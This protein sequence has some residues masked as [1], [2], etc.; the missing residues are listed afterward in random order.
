MIS[1]YFFDIRTVPLQVGC[2]ELVNPSLRWQFFQNRVRKLVCPIE[3]GNEICKIATNK[4]SF[5]V[6]L[7]GEF[8]ACRGPHLVSYCIDQ[9]LNVVFVA[10]VNNTI[11]VLQS[12]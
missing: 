1:L 6:M 11:I 7:S 4:E 5:E 9:P 10:I 3:E 8:S 12:Q 2:L